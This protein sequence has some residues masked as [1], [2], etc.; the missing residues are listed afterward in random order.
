MHFRRL[1]LSTTC[2]SRR[3][4]GKM[5]HSLVYKAQVYFLATSEGG[6]QHD[7][8]KMLR[9]P[10]R[11]GGEY[12]DCCVTFPGSPPHALGRSYEVT[13]EFLSPELA[14]EVTAKTRQFELWEGKTIA[15]GEFVHVPR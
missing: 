5:R 6:R 2:L 1:R 11:I 8:G 10:M 13:I 4:Q 7:L 12:L 14:R 3:E 15:R 9:V